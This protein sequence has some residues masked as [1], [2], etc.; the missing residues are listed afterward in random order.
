MTNKNQA[1]KVK[2]GLGAS[3]RKGIANEKAD[4]DGRLDATGVLHAKDQPTKPVGAAIEG[5]PLANTYG[6]RTNASA[7]LPRVRILLTELVSNPF[8]PRE[9]YSPMAIDDLAVRLKREGQHVPITVTRNHRHPGKY[10]IVDGE[11]R[12]RAKKSLGEP[13]IDAEIVPDLSDQDLYLRAS[14]INK[15]RTKQTVFDDAVAWTR[16]LSEGIFETQDALAESL[17][18]SKALVSKTLL[19]GKLQKHYLQQL[20]DADGIGL[21]HA[22]N[23]KLIFDRVR[24]DVAESILERVVQGEMSVRRLE[25]YV[26]KLEGASPA[27]ATKTHYSGNVP[28]HTADGRDIGALKRYRDGRTELKLIGLNEDQQTLLVAR[29]EGLIREFIASQLS[30]AP[31]AEPL[32]T[33]EQQSI[34]GS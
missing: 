17:G 27:R 22:Y 20:A 31:R 8:N 28:F 29:L 26:K 32:E 34:A 21:A 16:V 3:I 25:E 33:V 1:S 9:F 12:F 14:S 19:I 30:S 13:S 24:V 10:V 2:L 15:N 5:D 6:S 4:V 7:V 18:I 11:F 23:V